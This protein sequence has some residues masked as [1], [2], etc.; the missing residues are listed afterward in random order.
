MTQ[1]AVTRRVLARELAVHAATRPLNIIA[2]AG[3]VVAAILLTPWLLPV[4]AA[5]YAALV[6][7]TFLDED[8]AES[9]GRQVY[10]RARRPPP[11]AE[12]S[13]LSPAV[14][15]R[16]A[17]AREAGRRVRN[18]VAESQVPL[19]DVET[20]VERLMREVEK[21]ARNAD[22]VATY[23]AEEGEVGLRR[24][25]E[26]LR[27]AESGDSQLDAATAQAAAA[28]RDQ[29]DARAHLSR[30]LSYFDAQME[31][32]VATLGLI[33]A[34]IVRVS[35]AEEASAQ[36]RVADQVRHLRHEV[37]AIADALDQAYRDLD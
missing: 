23:L 7:T 6:V 19:A 28:L 29:L 31:H 4:A 32:L 26:Q 34:Q 8:V 37:D 20:E 25:L 5:V 18:A 27:T 33:R 14:A 12:L 22:Q 2:P 3:V 15:D 13:K 36:H 11:R 10:A 21:L 17:L 1:T 35:V 30:Q 16:L 24:R 9:V